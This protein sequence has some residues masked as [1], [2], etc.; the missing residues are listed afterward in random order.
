MP[1]N[2]KNESLVCLLLVLGLQ[3]EQEG[4]VVLRV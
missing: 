4:I 2:V 1:D 3:A